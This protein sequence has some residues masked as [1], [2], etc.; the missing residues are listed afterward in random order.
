MA[1]LPAATASVQAPDPIKAILRGAINRRMSIDAMLSGASVRSFAR[2]VPMHRARRP[3]IFR[4]L[5]FQLLKEV[6]VHL[7]RIEG[8]AGALPIGLVQTQMIH[9]AINGEARREAVIGIAHMPVEIDPFRF[10][11]DLTDRELRHVGMLNATAGARALGPGRVP[12]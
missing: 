5:V 8:A 9:Q 1:A 10:D 4:R 3:T 6:N 2:A 7:E 12:E 11:L